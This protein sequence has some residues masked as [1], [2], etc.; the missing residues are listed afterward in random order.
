M[1]LRSPTPLLSLPI[2]EKIPLIRETLREHSALILEASPGSGKTTRVPAAL[3]DEPWTSGKEI[4]VLVPRR[5]AARAAAFR[6]AEE[7]GEAAGETVGYHFRFEKKT[8]PKTRLKFLTEGMFLRLVLTEP[9]LPRVAAVILDEF[10]ERHLQ[11]DVALG[12]LQWLRAGSRPDL[13]IIVMSATLSAAALSRFLENAPSLKIDAK[14]YPVTVSYAPLGARE[15]LEDGVRS[16]VASSLASRRGDMLVFLPGV[17]DIRR[18]E[19]ALRGAFRDEVKILPLYA[20]LSPEEQSQV[21]RPAPKPKVILATNVAE[22]SLTIDGVTTVIDG[23]LHRRASFSW[24]SG[25][26]RLVTRPISKASA[27][28]RAGRAGRTAPGHCLR[29]YAESD[30]R[31]RPEYDVPEIARSDLSETFLT[32]AALGITKE[33]FAWFDAPPEASLSAAEILLKRLGAIDDRGVTALGR[34]MAEFPLHP[35]LARVMLEGEAQ[36]IAEGAATVVSWI[37]EGDIAETNLLDAL[38]QPPPFNVR[39]LRDRLVVSPSSKKNP[40]SGNKEIAKCLLAG[41]PDRVA[42]KR[43]KDLVFAVSG[44][45]LLPP[46]LPQVFRDNDHFLVLDVQE[47]GRQGEGRMQVHVHTVCP[48]RADWLLDV[49]SGDLLQEEEILFWDRDLKKVYEISRLKYGELIL[50]EDRSEPRDREGATKLL[51]KEAFGITETLSV[52]DLLEALRHQVDPEPVETLLARLKILKEFRKEENAEDLSA[53]FLSSLRGLTS[54]RDLKPAEFA[55]RFRDNLPHEIASALHR[56]VPET[57]ILCGRRV[58]IHYT[59][60]QSP[61]MASRLQDFLGMKEGPKILEGRLP[62]ALHLLLPNKRPVQI[63]KDLTS[64]WKNTYPQVRKEMMRKY[65]RHKWPED[66]LT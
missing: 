32:I 9:Q 23:G 41:F 65:P 5:I 53:L 27:I 26:P 24:W 42:A 34:R 63:T 2:D 28:Q 45:A 47:R 55:N 66:P 51:L 20:D 36:G 40:S 21:F 62:L 48:I 57:L 7:R 54:L 18:C 59:W 25:I 50:S 6:V 52:P 14:P 31:G 35:R 13:K 3:L 60:N 49:K 22:T 44:S 11:T 39:R 1:T 16:A 29:L 58:A 19:E 37:S 15:R 56:L 46:S 33:N 64:F 10:H 4:W 12:Y 43:S 8:G 38:S 30:F 61:W 17:G